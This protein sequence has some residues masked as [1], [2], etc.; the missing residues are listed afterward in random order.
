MRVYN[1]C[2]EKSKQWE[3]RRLASRNIHFKGE[4]SFI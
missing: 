3:G 1:K 2:E 4:P